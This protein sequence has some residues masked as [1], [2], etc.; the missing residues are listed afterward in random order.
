MRPSIVAER[1]QLYKFASLDFSSRAWAV[2]N[3]S[4]KMGRKMGVRQA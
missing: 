4:E 3:S 1:S 2:V